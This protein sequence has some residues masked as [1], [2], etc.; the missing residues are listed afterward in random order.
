MHGNQYHKPPC[1]VAPVFADSLVAQVDLDKKQYRDIG[2]SHL[3][4]T[5]NTQNQ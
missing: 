3:L 5:A 4:N 2:V 1:I